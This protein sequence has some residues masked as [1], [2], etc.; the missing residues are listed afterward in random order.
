LFACPF[1]YRKSSG[2]VGSGPISF[3]LDS[4]CHGIAVKRFVGKLAAACRFFIWAEG[5][6]PQAQ[7]LGERCDTSQVS[8]S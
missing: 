6:W 7:N 5:G 1:P 8:V 3:D 4:P 2:L